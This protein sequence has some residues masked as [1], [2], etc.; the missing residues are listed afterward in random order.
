MQEQ[1]NLFINDEV[2]NKIKAFTRHSSFDLPH[3]DN[4]QEIK[5]L[6]YYILAFDNDPYKAAAELKKAQILAQGA[7]HK[8]LDKK[9][10]K[11][12]ETWNEK[13]KPFFESEEE[14][15]KYKEEAHKDAQE[16][17]QQTFYDNFLTRVS[18]FMMRFKDHDDM[19]KNAI[20]KSDIQG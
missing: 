16:A 4:H 11:F 15:T 17:L 7:A 6:H 9:F 3:P 19:V 5:L 8:I 2:W 18:N 14:F 20:E 13:T 1:K 12:P 10:D